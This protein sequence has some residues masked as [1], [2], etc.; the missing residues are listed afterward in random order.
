[1]ITI[2]IETTGAAFEE[3]LMGESARILQH[4]ASRMT[5]GPSC[6]ATDCSLFDVNGN[7][8]GTAQWTPDNPDGPIET[9]PTTYCEPCR[10][11]TATRFDPDGNGFCVECKQQKSGNFIM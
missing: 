8:C 7:R 2:T 4:L 3:D 6:D 1:M 5:G 10:G 9:E 11:E